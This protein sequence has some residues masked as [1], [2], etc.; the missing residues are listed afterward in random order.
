MFFAHSKTVI[1]RGTHQRV[2]SNVLEATHHL[3]ASA[4]NETKRDSI[5][6]NRIDEKTSTN[7]IVDLSSKLSNAVDGYVDLI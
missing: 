5:R 2:S 4:H 6:F 7:H 1:I 3:S